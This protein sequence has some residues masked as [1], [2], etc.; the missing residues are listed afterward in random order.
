LGASRSPNLA[1]REGTIIGGGRYS[2]NVRVQ[3]D[4]YKSPTSLHL[5]YIELIS[6]ESG[7]PRVDCLE[8]AAPRATLPDSARRT[9]SKKSPP[10]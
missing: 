7:E 9:R 5:D 1:N 4:G 10:G 2:S 6:E 8:G 3:F